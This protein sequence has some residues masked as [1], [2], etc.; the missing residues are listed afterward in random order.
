MPLVPAAVSRYTRGVRRPIAEIGPDR[1]EGC[2]VAEFVI[3]V[4][5]HPSG[6]GS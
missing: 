3:A 1:K 2:E 5:P 4:M 6:T